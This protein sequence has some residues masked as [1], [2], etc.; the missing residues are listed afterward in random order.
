MVYPHKLA[1]STMIIECKHAKLEMERFNLCYSFTLAKD[2][3][4]MW[5]LAGATGR[6]HPTQLV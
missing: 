3:I 6:S 1:L 2:T 4:K 5:E